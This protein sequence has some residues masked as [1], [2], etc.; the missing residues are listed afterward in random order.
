[1]AVSHGLRLSANRTKS[2]TGIGRFMDIALWN[3][4]R[5]DFHS[6]GE[7]HPQCMRRGRDNLLG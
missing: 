6:R 2:D 3:P 1:M 7:L 4:A 5:A